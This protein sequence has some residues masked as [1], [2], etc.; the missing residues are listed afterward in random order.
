MKKY[1][2]IK[3][4][5]DQPDKE[6]VF[7]HTRSERLKKFYHEKEKYYSI[8]KEMLIPDAEI[9]FS[10]FIQRNLDFMPLL[11]VVDNNPV[12]LSEGLLKQEGNFLIKTA[13]IALYNKYIESLNG[14]RGI[15]NRKFLAVL[16]KEKF[17]ILMQ[18]VF[19]NPTDSENIKRC[20][21]SI[22]EII[23]SIYSRKEIFY[24]LISIKS[25]DFY[26]YIHSVNVAIL[27]IGLGLVAKLSE[28]DLYNLGLGAILHDIGKCAISNEI[29]N[30]IGRLTVPEYKVMK[31]HVLEGQKILS[32]HQDFPQ[33]A[34]DAVAQHHERLSGKG[35]PL[36][37]TG[38]NITIFG[39]IV[40]I[41]D[42]YDSLTT[43]RLDKPPLT[44]FE[45]LSI[46]VNECEHYDSELLKKFIKLIGGINE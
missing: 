34:L 15:K 10:L 9:L 32:R 21:Q 22:K 18:E 17:K 41:T 26:T 23:K 25:H 3:E 44:P 20:G 46:L 28:R 1:I 29:L 12:R 40:A 38:A 4:D 37:L 33:D 24:D 27:S 43:P 31:T 13:D 19:S 36:N 39:R 30:K 11:T 5:K 6:I 45:A 7:V 42:S 2:P 35:Y 14:E 8:D 16:M